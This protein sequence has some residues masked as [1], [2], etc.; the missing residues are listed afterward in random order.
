VEPT[1]EAA[2]LPQLSETTTPPCP[3]ARV[4]ASGVNLRPSAGKAE[5]PL[6][7][8]SLDERLSVLDC[9]GEPGDGFLWWEVEG[10]D[11]IRGWVATD[12]L[13]EVG[14]QP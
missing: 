2:A 6:R 13:E 3:A 5:P 9:R 1:L 7:K 14:S 4:T 12:W 10:E 11:G 8:L